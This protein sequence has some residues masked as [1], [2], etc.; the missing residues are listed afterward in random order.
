MTVAIFVVFYLRSQV[1]YVG[2]GI[3][4]HLMLASSYESEHN[5]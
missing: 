5:V 4:M 3:I 2:T 1:S